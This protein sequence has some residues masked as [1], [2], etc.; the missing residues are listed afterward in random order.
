MKVTFLTETF[1]NITLAMTGLIILTFRSQLQKHLTVSWNEA[2]RRG[3]DNFVAQKKE[4][5][6]NT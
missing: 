1:L 5:G 6:Y 3:N 2:A 4:M